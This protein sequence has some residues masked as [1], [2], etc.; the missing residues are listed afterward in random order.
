MG[1]VSSSLC[2][3]HRYPAEIVSH[4]VSLPPVH[5]EL[6]RVEEMVLE[7]GVIVSYETIRG[8]GSQVRSGLRRR[9]H[10]FSQKCSRSSAGG[11]PFRRAL[12]AYQGHLGGPP[13]GAN[14]SRSGVRLHPATG[15]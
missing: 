14:R 6:P 3:D 2:K 8:W 9:P 4:C 15:R 10:R 13:A 1:V 11:T 12:P 5:A 7:G